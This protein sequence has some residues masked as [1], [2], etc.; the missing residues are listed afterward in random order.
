MNLRGRVYTLDKK[1]DEAKIIAGKALQ[2]QH[3]K[4]EKIL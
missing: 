1:R 3:K 2:A 4:F